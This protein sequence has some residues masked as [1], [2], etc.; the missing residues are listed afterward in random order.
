MNMEV[1]TIILMIMESALLGVIAGIEIRV[2]I[3]L[4]IL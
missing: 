3:Q 1:K 2:I 4:G